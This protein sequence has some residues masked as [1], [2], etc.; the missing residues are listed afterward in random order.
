M[1]KIRKNVFKSL[2]FVCLGLTLATIAFAST[3]NPFDPPSAPG[4]PQFV[5][6]WKDGC[7]IRYDKPI[8]DGGAPIL[9]YLI[10][11]KNDSWG[12]DRWVDKGA[13]RDL[14][15]T[16][17]DMKEGSSASFRV[18]AVNE[19]GKGPASKESN[20]VKFEDPF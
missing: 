17:S 20:I 14:E 4:K 13:T 8:H 3:R 6:V 18:F 19:A 1:K 2:L 12:W 16:I 10:E 9:L 11:G 7:H 15:F 5:D